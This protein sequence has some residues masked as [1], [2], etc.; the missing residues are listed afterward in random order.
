[1]RRRRHGFV[2]VLALTLITLVGVAL[3]TITARLRTSVIQAED[4]RRRAQ[5][6][7][8][9]LAGIE[10]AR[11]GVAEGKHD[12]P[13]PAGLAEEGAKLTVTGAGKR[14]V[15]EAVLGTTRGRQVVEAE[16][17]TVRL[18]NEE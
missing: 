9:L 12:V 18:V 3:T 16:A 5:V 4:A 10:V 14:A 1:M 6:E 8:L 17:G 13:L 11:E 2:M 15:I 7:Q